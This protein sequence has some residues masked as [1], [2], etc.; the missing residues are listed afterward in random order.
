M[1]KTIVIG[2]L[3]RDPEMR[4]TR[5]GTAVT[6]FSVAVKDKGYTDGEEVEIT[7]WYRI[8]TWNKLA[9]ACQQYLN[10]G[11]KVYVEGKLVADAETGGPRI[12]GEEEAKANF[13]INAQIVEFLVTK[14][15]EREGTPFDGEEE[16]PK[17]KAKPPA[18]GAKKKAGSQPW[19][20][21]E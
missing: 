8:S 20:T 5:S 7:V 4:Y 13:E 17:R 16:A 10:K 18:P 1:H 9:E 21:G 3:G 14:G 19:M 15:G 2:H 12:W 11:D 6:N